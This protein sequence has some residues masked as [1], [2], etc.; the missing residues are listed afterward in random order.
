MQDLRGRRLSIVHGSLDGLVDP[1]H[2]RVLGD[3]ARAAG[4][5][6]EVWLVAD[7]GHV[8]AVLVHPDEYERRLGRFFGAAFGR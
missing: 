5:E 3:A 2:A 4:V 8:D 7:A 1:A 6:V